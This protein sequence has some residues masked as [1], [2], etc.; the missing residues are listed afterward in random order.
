MW[1]GMVQEEVLRGKAKVLGT[2]EELERLA[3]LLREALVQERS[4][5]E[6]AAQSAAEESARATAAQESAAKIAELESVSHNLAFCRGLLVSIACKIQ[7]TSE[8][9]L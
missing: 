2:I 6:A 7:L 8:V 5:L 9:R 4:S 3:P 1:F